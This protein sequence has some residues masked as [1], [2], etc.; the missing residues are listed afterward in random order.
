ML[1]LPGVRYASTG[2]VS[3]AV[4]AQAAAAN[5]SSGSIYCQL[6]A[7]VTLPG[8]SIPTVCA[9]HY[10]PPIITDILATTGTPF[11]VR[12]VLKT[13]VLSLFVVYTART[14]AARVRLVH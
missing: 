7:C 13:A 3:A 5:S 6:A 11:Q 2:A 8:S 9:H 1:G 14:L 4:A 12:Y 10:K